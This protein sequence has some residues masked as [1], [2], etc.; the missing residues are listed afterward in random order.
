MHNIMEGIMHDVK[1]RYFFAFLFLGVCSPA[2]A[3]VKWFSDY[4][5]SM[6]PTPL[7]EILNAKFFLLMIFATCVVFLA[8]MVDSAWKVDPPR[9]FL[10]RFFLPSQDYVTL[11]IRISTGIFFFSLWLQGKVILTPEILRVD[12]QF[13]EAIQLVIAVAT[14]SRRWCF[15]SGIGILVLYGYSAY[16]HGMFHLLDYVFFLGFANY[17]IWCPGPNQNQSRHITILYVTLALSLMWGAMEKFSYPYWYFPLLDDKPYL[18]F[19]FD[20]GTFV[21]LAGFVELTLGFLLIFSRNSLLFFAIGLNAIFIVAIADFG[22]VDAIGHL[23]IMSV[24]AVMALEGPSR[25][26][27]VTFTSGTQ[28][29]SIRS[30]MITTLF[31]ITSLSLLAL[32]H[33]LQYCL[34]P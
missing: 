1:W 29:A 7:V 30:A 20:Q 10:K 26:A 21:R 8:R 15:I 12:E 18:T 11:L 22:K 16:L 13:V 25:F 6:H 23:L 2:H 32:Y 3:H 27:T 31:V 33:V 4:D 34:S 14:L 28:S 24:L 19:G 17:L 9:V 5:L